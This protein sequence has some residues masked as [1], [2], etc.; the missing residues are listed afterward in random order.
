MAWRASA[1]FIEPQT[2][3]A[4][5]LPV[6]EPRLVVVPIRQPRVERVV[7]AV[8]DDSPVL[9]GSTVHIRGQRLRSDQLEVFVG[10]N[11]V[12]PTA[13]NDERIVLALPAGLEAG[14][15]SVQVRHRVL[16]GEPPVPHA[17]FESNPG[18]F[19]LHP[20]IAQDSAG[21]YLIAVANVVGEGAEPRSADVTVTTTTSVGRRQQVTLELLT[22]VGT[23]AR[24][25]HGFYVNALAADGT[26]LVF[27]LSRVVAGSYLARIRVN[28]AESPL[29]RD[30][31]AGSPTF[32]QPIAPTL[33]LP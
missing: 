22:R 28:G 7:A 31:T 18:E 6:R 21:A 32:G 4:P 11:A 30:T 8:G 16:M 15:Q 2:R 12:A 9:P 5:A 13:A 10:G 17:G 26:T 25:V 20:Q 3:I 33:T 14:P 23:D 24:V 1:V 19:V 27:A 29:E